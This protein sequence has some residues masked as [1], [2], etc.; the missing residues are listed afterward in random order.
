MV[1]RVFRSGCVEH[2]G[3]KLHPARP[4]L[5]TIGSDWDDEDNDLLCT[6][7]PLTDKACIHTSVS[8]RAC[9]RAY[10]AA[11]VFVVNLHI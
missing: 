1:L 9:V 8:Y 11:Q 2:R 3:L 4:L 10:V 5:S 7:E 6:A